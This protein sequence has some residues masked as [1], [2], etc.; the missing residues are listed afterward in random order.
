[1]VQSLHQDLILLPWWP[2]VKLRTSPWQTSEPAKVTKFPF[3]YKDSRERR[4]THE[5]HSGGLDWVWIRG[6]HLSLERDSS[7]GGPGACRHRT[8][9]RT[10][11]CGGVSSSQD[12]DFG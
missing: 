1:M 9:K 2:F 8:K 3:T 12:P 4:R 10:R 5:M 7:G 11:S 6:T